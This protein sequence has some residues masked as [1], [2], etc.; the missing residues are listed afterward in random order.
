MTKPKPIPWWQIPAIVTAV[1]AMLGVL[2]TLAVNY[3]TY[4]TLPSKVEAGEQKNQTQDKQIDRLI[5]LQEYYQKQQQA[6]NQV[7]RPTGLREWDDTQ[8]TFWCCDLPDRQSCF[9]QQQWRTCQ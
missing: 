3:A 5:T 7:S 8:R 4:A 1:I 2:G 6:P 9:D